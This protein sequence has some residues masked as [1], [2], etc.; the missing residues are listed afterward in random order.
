MIIFFEIFGVI[1]VD[2]I[3]NGCFVDD[4]KYCGDVIKLYGYYFLLWVFDRVRI[5]INF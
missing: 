3:L 1:I 2:E 4:V 5:M